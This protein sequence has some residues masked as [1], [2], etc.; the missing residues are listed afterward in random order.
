MASNNYNHER[1]F[2]SYQWDNQTEVMKL[3]VFLKQKGYN[4]WMD[5]HQMS[6]GS[7]LTDRISDAILNSEIFIACITRGYAASVMCRNEIHLA[8]KNKKNII[9]LLYDDVN[10][11]D[12]R[13]ISL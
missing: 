11:T 4:A 1:I 7:Y 13:G 2:L 12:M 9:P 6:A 10:D 5:I 8:H 3:K